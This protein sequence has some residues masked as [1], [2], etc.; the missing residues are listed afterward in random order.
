MDIL[1]TLENLVK[2]LVEDMGAELVDMQFNRGKRTS[3]RIF[4]WQDGGISLDKCTEISREV[5]DVL[6]RKN[7]MNGKYVLEVSSPGIDRPLVTQRDYQRQVDRTVKIVKRIDEKKT[8]DIVGHIKSATE[9]SVHLLV[10]DELLEIKFD[11][12]VSAKIKVEF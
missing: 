8:K 9:T 11:E 1:T 7:V 3:V 2:P 6:D 5:S 4:V 10:D 12:I